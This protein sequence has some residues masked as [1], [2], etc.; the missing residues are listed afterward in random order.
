MSGDELDNAF[1]ENVMQ[2][3]N[4]KIEN[5]VVDEDDNWFAV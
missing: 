4:V 1:D 3:I 5:V 2:I